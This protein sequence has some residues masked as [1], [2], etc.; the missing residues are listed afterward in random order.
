MKKSI[1]FLASMICL[2]VAVSFVSCDKNDDEDPT[3][4]NS[5]SGS[6]SS[7]SGSSSSGGGSSVSGVWMI[8]CLNWGASQSEVRD[9]MNGFSGWTLTSSDERTL[10][11]DHKTYN[12][13]VSYV[14]ETILSSNSPLY[15]VYY[16]VGSC[17]ESDFNSYKSFLES[18]FTFTSME[19][20]DRGEGSITYYCSFNYEGKSHGLVLGYVKVTKTITAYFLQ[21][22]Y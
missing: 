5:S 19:R 13:T 15:A 17:S 16:T 22:Q 2:F 3:S 6:S 10:N 8:P 11:Y 4:S 20:D 18:K 21:S 1:L 7:E 14:F 12:Q 9:Y